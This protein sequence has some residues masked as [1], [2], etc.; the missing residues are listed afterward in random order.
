[1]SIVTTIGSI[2][3]ALPLVAGGSTYPT[4]IHGLKSAQNMEA[5]EV[6]NVMVFLDEPITSNDILTQGGYIEEEYPLFMFFGKRCDEMDHN[7]PQ[8]R[9]IADEMRELS[10]RFILRLQANSNIRFVKNSTR[11]DAFFVFDVNL[12]GVIAKITV[13]PK[14]SD[15]ACV[16]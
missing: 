9:I 16:D 6:Q 2:V 14:N 1:M 13:V 10:K 12:H 15:G 8:L 11:I 3:G 5:D 4:F 7:S